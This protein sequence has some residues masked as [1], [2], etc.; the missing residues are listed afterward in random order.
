MTFKELYK[1]AKKRP[2]AGQLFISDVARMTCR[3]ETT[4]KMWLS[5]RQVPDALACKVIA[6]NYGV[7]E[8][9]LFPSADGK[10]VCCD[11]C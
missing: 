9:E 4:V 2:T 1:T 10:G 8:D 5:G 11:D 6:R 7:G 3:S